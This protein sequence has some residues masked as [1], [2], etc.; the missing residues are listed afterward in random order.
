MFPAIRDC[1]LF[2]I[3]DLPDEATAAAV[4][5]NIGAAGTLGVSMTVPVSPETVD[6]A[7]PKAVPYRLPGAWEHPWSSPPRTRV[8]RQ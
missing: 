1:D 8:R 7:V 4:S 6:E 5:L 3:A 2:L